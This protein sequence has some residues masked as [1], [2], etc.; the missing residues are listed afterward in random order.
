MHRTNIYLDDRQRRELDR[1]AG[2]EGISRAELI[3]QVLDRWLDGGQRDEQSD[4]GAIDASFGVLADV[5]VPVRGDDLR[6]AH[7]AE[8]W[9]LE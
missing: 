8:M 6:A 4:L 1:V 3:R 2:G 9:R 7:L 5:E